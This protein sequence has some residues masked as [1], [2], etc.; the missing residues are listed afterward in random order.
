MRKCCKNCLC[1]SC[2]NVCGCCNCHR[3]NHA[4]E[5]C[6]QYHAFKQVS[7]YDLY[8]SNRKLPRDKT[9]D[10][11]GITRE[12]YKELREKCRK[13]EF[14]REELLTACKG[15]EYISP[16]IILS[17]TQGKS[18]DKLEYDLRLGR[19]PCGRTDFYGYIRLFYNSLNTVQQH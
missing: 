10:D 6:E 7:I 19:I 14:S 3:P 18:Y 16:W 12:H 1:S 9:F 4:T 11:Y 17:V 13:G 15:F 2:L 8:R 5:Q